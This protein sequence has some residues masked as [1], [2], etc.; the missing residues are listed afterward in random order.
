MPSLLEA[1]EGKYGLGGS[2]DPQEA[3]VSVMFFVLWFACC[4]IHFE[5]AF[6][7]NFHFFSYIFRFLF[8][9]MVAVTDFC[10]KTAT[11]YAVSITNDPLLLLFSR[12]F[13]LLKDFAAFSHQKTFLRSEKSFFYE[14]LG[15]N[16]CSWKMFWFWKNFLLFKDFA[17]F[18]RFWW[19]WKIFLVLKDLYLN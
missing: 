18:Q 2:C 7:I 6:S 17:A 13:Q 15:N 11:T 4:S 16:F 3:S 9:T 5:W 14:A 1:I 19:S 12:I 10:A 8:E